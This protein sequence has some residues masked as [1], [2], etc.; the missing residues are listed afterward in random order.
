MDSPMET[1]LLAVMEPDSASGLHP[2]L[3]M[4]VGE[5]GRRDRAGSPP[6]AILPGQTWRFQCWHRDGNS[7]N[8]TDAVAVTFL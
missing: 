8:F 6:V 1:W 5:V 2:T 4:R 7:N 3:H